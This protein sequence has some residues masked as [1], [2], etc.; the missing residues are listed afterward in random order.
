MHTRCTHDVHLHAHGIHTQCTH[1]AHAMH[2]QCTQCTRDAHAMHTMH[3][4]CTHDA[5]NAHTMHTRCTHDAHAMHTRCTHC[6]RDA[7][8]IHTMRT[9]CTRDAHAMHTRCTRDAHTCCTLRALHPRVATGWPSPP[10]PPRPL[11]RCRGPV[12]RPHVSAWAAPRARLGVGGWGRGWAQLLLPVCRCTHAG[13]V[14]P[15]PTRRSRDPMGPPSSATRLLPPLILALAGAARGTFTVGAWPRVAVVAFGGSVAIN[16]SRSACPGGNATL[17]LET[18]LTVIRGAGGLRW[19]N[20]HLLNVSRWN[21]GAATCRGRC[22]ESQANASAGILVYRL[23]ERVVLEPVAAVAVGESRNL[24]CRVLEVAP[25]GNLTVTLRRGTET[26][27]T[28][29]FGSAEGSASVAVT[30]LLTASPG[31]HGQDVTC[32]AELSLR[33][34]GPLFARA[35]VPVKLSVFAL[36][37]PPQLRAPPHLEAGTTGTASCQ[38]AGAFPVEDVHFAMALAEQNL[39]FTVTVTGDVV[40]TVTVLSPSTP[41]RQELTCTAAVATVART[42]R[43]QLH[44]Y[45]FPAPILELSPAAAPAGSEVTVTCHAGVAEPPA[46]RLQ[47]RDADGGVLAEGPRSQ[48]ELRLVAR[49]EDDG[50]RFGCRASLAIGAGAVTKDADAR[51]AVLYIP[52]ISASDCPANRTWLRGTREALSCRATGN[53]A[54]AV[55]CAWGHAAGMSPS[56]WSTS[57]P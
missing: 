57:P 26:L 43:R 20:F 27:R 8:T 39:N 28:E 17:G 22:G 49:R 13:P 9:R 18:P 1:D 4:R 24:T 30:H 41:G 12:P 35:A 45:R 55:V 29:S 19:Q 16:C 53:P 40:T 21:P 46:V 37:E 25:L 44:V 54:P 42:A 7:H 6:T 50:R 31:D 36:P 5:H 3:T 48:L 32:H 10:A 52:E 15:T 14:A 33:P 38:I 34:H 23:P 56:A 11:P 51:L 47:L 2:K